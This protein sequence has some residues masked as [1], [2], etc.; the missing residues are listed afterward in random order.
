MRCTL[1]FFMPLEEAEEPVPRGRRTS[2]SC[3]SG[4]W[5]GRTGSTGVCEACKPSRSPRGMRQALVLLGLIGTLV[6][7]GCGGATAPT[8]M[9]RALRG[10]GGCGA[11][12][13]DGICPNPVVYSGFANA[14]L[15]AT[16]ESGSV[17]LA[18]TTADAEGNFVLGLP[19]GTYRVTVEQMPGYGVLLVVTD[20]PTSTTLSFYQPPP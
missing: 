16:T 8:V 7:A 9:G 3:W 1:A 13:P 14:R 18:T 15:R 2:G 4:S 11:P 6:L 17:V 19:A 10:S 5:R 12:P 20:P